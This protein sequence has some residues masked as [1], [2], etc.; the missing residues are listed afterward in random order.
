[1]AT[2]Q[3][4]AANG[5]TAGP[6]ANRAAAAV[7]QST[8]SAAPENLGDQPNVDAGRGTTGAA[9]SVEPGVTAGAGGAVATAACSTPNETGPIAIGA[10]GNLSGPAGSALAGTEKGLQVW[11]SWVNQHGGLCGRQVQVIVVDDHSDPAQ[12][13]AALQDL[14]ENRHVVAFSNAA[15]LTAEAGISYIESV[16]VPVIGSACANEPEFASAM[17][18]LVCAHPADLTYG[19]AKNAALFGPASHRLA[20]VTC[21][22]SAACGSQIQST[23]VAQGGAQRAGMTLVY[24]AQASIAQPDFTSECQG[25][26]AAGGDVFGVFL[27]PASMRRLGRSCERQGYLPTYTQ[28]AAT[29]DASL[30]TEPGLGNMLLVSPTFSFVDASTPAEQEFQ[31]AMASLYGSAP[32]PAESQGW[33]HGKLI[34]RAATIAAQTSGSITS[35]TLIDALHTLHDETLGGLTVPV[36]YPA[37]G[38]GIYPA[39]WFA[40]EAVDG[41]W[42]TLNAGQPVCR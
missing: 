15:T 4:L 27:D 29:V 39:C 28:V 31:Q 35:A 34:E 30:P 16:R 13:R 23:L 14:V 5:A 10:V 1:M 6:V 2:A 7:A 8:A 40:M 32:G 9:S 24:N 22:E 12:Y 38:P 36:T 41:N 42:T 37:G 19:T 3:L 17:Y 11:G 18:Y 21:R 25:A 26:R 33:A 20:I